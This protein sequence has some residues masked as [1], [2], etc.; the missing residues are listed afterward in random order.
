MSHKSTALCV[1]AMAILGL[2]AASANAGV[3]TPIFTE[4]F[5]AITA[6]G[7]NFNGGPAGQVT[8]GHD[9]VWGASLTGWSKSGAGAIHA[10]D[11]ANTWPGGPKK[12]PL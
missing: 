6:P 5:D 3:I 8:T 1:T 4:N 10:V 7:G 9:L 2:M 12:L 11:T